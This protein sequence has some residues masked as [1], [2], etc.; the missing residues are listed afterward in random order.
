MNVSSETL[1]YP[2]NHHHHH[3]GNRRVVP[4]KHASMLVSASPVAVNNKIRAIQ[5]RK[6]RI[7]L[8]SFYDF[9]DIRPINLTQGRTTN[10]THTFSNLSPEKLVERSKDLRLGRLVPRQNQRTSFLSS[11][12]AANQQS[13]IWPSYDSPT[14]FVKQSQ[15]DSIIVSSTAVA[16]TINKSPMPDIQPR[17][18][19]TA[20]RA[21]LTE[22]QTNLI[23]VDSRNKSVLKTKNSIPKAYD[24]TI[25]KVKSPYV[26]TNGQPLP[27]F[28]NDYFKQ[29]NNNIIQIFESEEEEEE[30]EEENTPLVMDEEFQK[31]VEKA[32]VKCADWLIKY[33]FDK[34]YDNDDE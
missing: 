6:P 15:I 3:H 31:Y 23:P 20:T 24:R 10:S 29:F 18:N 22:Q 13:F 33:V 11:N 27:M 14:A 32:I 5:T 16:P 17:T 1:A 26:S 19:R 30:P 9:T 28:Q 8:Q 25:P 34:T 7:N 4:T 21:P 12:S 2:I